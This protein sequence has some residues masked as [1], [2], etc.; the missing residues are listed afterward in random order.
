MRPQNSSA[1]QFE[2]GGQRH[3]TRQTLASHRTG[4]H[5]ASTELQSFGSED[6]ARQRAQALLQNSGDL[7]PVVGGKGHKTGLA[8][9]GL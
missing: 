8:A 6:R 1:L 7:V 5:L 3:T 9:T 4:H 2:S